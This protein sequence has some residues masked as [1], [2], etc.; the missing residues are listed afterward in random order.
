[1]TTKEKKGLLQGRLPSLRDNGRGSYHADK[2]TFL[3]E[4][5]RAPVTDYLSDANQKI[6]Y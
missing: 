3:W 1:M 5:Q 4:M 6:P 2:V